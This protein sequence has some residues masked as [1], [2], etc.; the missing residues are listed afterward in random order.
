[1]TNSNFKRKAKE[2][3]DRYTGIYLIVIIFLI[4]GIAVGSIMSKILKDSQVQNLV[5]FLNSYFK[6]LDKSTV[7][8]IVLL[9]KSILNN[10]KTIMLLWVFGL[11]IIGAPLTFCL[12]SIRGFVMGFTVSFLFREYGIN[13]ALFALLAILPQNIFIIPGLII[14]SVISLSYSASVLKN[15]RQIYYKSARYKNLLNYS[16][17]IVLA[18]VILVIGSFMEAYITPMFMRLLLKS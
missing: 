8:S 2:H 3:F 16:L 9:K 10:L 17:A 1:M 15:K 4:L 11:I 7:G 18:S 6:I 14:L 5:S 13:G 12:I